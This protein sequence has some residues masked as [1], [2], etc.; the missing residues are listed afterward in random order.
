MT[1]N[2]VTVTWHPPNAGG[3]TGYK[4]HIAD[5]SGTDRSIDTRAARRMTF[6]ELSAGTQY[7]VV[8]VS[9]SGDQQSEMLAETFNTGKGIAL[10]Y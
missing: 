10:R 6:T 7:A 8:V 2:S 9:L 5:V 3:L 4:A 1:V